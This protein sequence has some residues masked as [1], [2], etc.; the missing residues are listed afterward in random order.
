MAAGAGALPQRTLVD[1]RAW[2]LALAVL[3][4][5]ALMLVPT[6]GLI[7]AVLAVLLLAA[8]RLWPA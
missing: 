8:G 6:A 3:A 1:P 5:P 2:A 4:L 7:L